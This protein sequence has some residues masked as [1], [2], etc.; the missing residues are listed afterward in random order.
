MVS[1]KERLIQET[2]RIIDECR[3][4]RQPLETELNTLTAQEN[5]AREMLQFLKVGYLP[6]ENGSSRRPP[7][8]EA[9]VWEVI[10]EMDQDFVATEL[11]EILECSREAAT[12]WC[13]KFVSQGRLVIARQGQGGGVPNIY[14]RV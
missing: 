12:S 10:E 2:E 8:K 14:R 9:E 13:K 6:Q 1:L 7:M 4:K 3:K 11:A 5:E